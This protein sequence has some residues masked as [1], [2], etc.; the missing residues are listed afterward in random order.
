MLRRIAAL[1]GTL[2][3]PAALLAQ[4]TSGPANV[5]GFSLGIALNGSAI[6]SDEV[7][8]GTDSGGGLTL[9]LGYGFT[10]RLLLFLDGT[11]A[12]I[13]ADGESWVLA[14][15]D[16]G[17]RFHFTAPGRG[18]TPFVEG[19]FTTRTGTQENIE[20]LDGETADL[21][22]SGP[23]FTAGA[24]FLYFFSPRTALSTGLRW[25]TGE[26]TTVKFGNV[27]VDG[28]DLDATSTRVNIGLTW[29]FANRR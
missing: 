16:L 15:G 28:L 6:S 4:G 26:F 29:F 1:L 21:E 5:K 25:T 20:F 14:H 24:G 19:A 2:A 12:S 27:S 7:A 23:G 18:F 13:R 11:A 3:V 8:D 22:I 9:G 10:P 17:L